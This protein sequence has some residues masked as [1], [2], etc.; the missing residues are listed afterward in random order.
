MSKKFIVSILVCFS[1]LSVAAQSQSCID[2][3]SKLKADI[4]EQNSLYEDMQSSRKLK[5]IIRSID[6]NNYGFTYAFGPVD[7]E[8]FGGKEAYKQCKNS[9]E[10]NFLRYSGHEELLSKQ[11]VLITCGRHMGQNL[12]QFKEIEAALK[13]A[14]KAKCRDMRADCEGLLS[15]LDNNNL[16]TTEALLSRAT[17]TCDYDRNRSSDSFTREEFRSL[18]SFMDNVTLA[19]HKKTAKSVLKLTKKLRKILK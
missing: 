16:T 7:Y 3:E 14:T 17:L 1:S 8:A 18:T 5:K 6:E 4:A 15:L 11:N 10:A 9:S 12:R 19:A 13:N 2:G